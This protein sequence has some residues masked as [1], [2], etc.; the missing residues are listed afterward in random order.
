MHKSSRYMYVPVPA[1]QKSGK[2]EGGHIK[3]TTIACSAATLAIVLPTRPIARL[4]VIAGR[5]FYGI[6][7]FRF[8]I[9]PTPATVHFH[10]ITSGRRHRRT[11][12]TMPR[13]SSP[14]HRRL[15]LYRDG[16]LLAF[17]AV[18]RSARGYLPV[19]S[20]SAKLGV[21]TRWKLASAKEHPLLGKLTAASWPT[22][23]TNRSPVTSD[24]NVVW[25]WVCGGGGGG[26]SPSL[27]VMMQC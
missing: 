16:K 25:G 24:R 3:C 12:D 10:Q 18:W 17:E 2:I 8:G 6:C 11:S 27:S 13:I 26:L 9:C 14:A 15:S 23:G 4:L 19:A 22:K 21:S 1:C 5:Q 20:E 7:N